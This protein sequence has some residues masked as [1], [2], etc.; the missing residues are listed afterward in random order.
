MNE[1][2]ENALVPRPPSAVQKAVPGA[3]R[4]LSGIVADTVTPLPV[5]LSSNYF[6]TDSKLQFNRISFQNSS[7]I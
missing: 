4:I 5:Q 1:K 6:G 7:L 3:K 2:K